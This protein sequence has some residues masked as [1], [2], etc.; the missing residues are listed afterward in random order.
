MEKGSGNTFEILQ[1]NSYK[2]YGML[3]RIRYNTVRSLF[4]SKEQS[5]QSRDFFKLIKYIF[6]RLCLINKPYLTSCLASRIS[7]SSVYL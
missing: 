4:W 1:G 7:S 5:Y 2:E 6:M 3:Q